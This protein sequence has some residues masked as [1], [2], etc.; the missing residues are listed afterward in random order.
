MTRRPSNPTARRTSA[1]CQPNGTGPYRIAEVKPGEYILMEKNADYFKDGFKGDPAISKIRF[2]TIKDANTRAA[3]LMTGA[4]DWIWDVPKDQAER[5]KANPAVVV[6]NA[7][8]LRVSYLQ[9]D[10]H[11]VSGQKLFTD[12][13]VRQ[14]V[15]HAINRE[16]LTKNLVGPGIGGRARRLPSRPVRLLER[17]AQVRLRS[18]QGQAR[19]SR[20]RAVA[21]GTEFDLFAYREREYTEAVIGDLAKVGLK[22]KLNYMQYTAFLEAVHKGRTPVAHG[23]WGSNSVPDVSAMT[24]HFFLHGPDDLTKDPEV[25]KLIEE[26][27][28]LTD[29]DKRKAVWQKALARIAA[30]AYW[31]PLFT[32]AKYY[33]FSKD[34]DF[35]PTSDEIPQFFAAKWK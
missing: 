18:R 26:A 35:T 27:D 29:P 6:E 31:V 9:F 4:I 15:A 3:E 14:A 19:S 17:R 20:R 23:T 2:R 34:L 5:I 24:A 12:K 11:G 30:E 8:T 1:P 13:R 21:E 10:A 22:P 28:A 32:Y 25:K 33:A 16:S 7:K